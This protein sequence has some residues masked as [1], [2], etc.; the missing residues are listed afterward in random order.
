MTGLPCLVQNLLTT[1]NLRNRRSPVMK[2]IPEKL[3]VA[4]L[5]PGISFDPQILLEEAPFTGIVCWIA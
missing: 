3:G 5:L 4:Q 2:N 1:R